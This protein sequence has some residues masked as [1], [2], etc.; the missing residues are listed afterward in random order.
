M[1]GV[2]HKNGGGAVGSADHGNGGSVRQIKEKACQEEG[3]K[4]AELCGCAEQHQPRALQKGPKVD[5]GTDADEQQQG[6]QLVAHARVEQS[7]D[8]ALGAALGDGARKGQVHQNGAEAHGH[9]KRGLHFFDNAKIDEQAAHDPHDQHLPCGV[10]Q[11][12]KQAHEG[13][14]QIHR[15][16]SPFSYTVDGVR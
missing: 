11:I 12:G 9:Q 14:E 3:E 15:N 6:E 16:I 1:Q 10:S 4:H 2:G 5:H 8:G 7:G 13:A